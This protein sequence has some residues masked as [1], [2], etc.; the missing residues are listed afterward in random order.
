MVKCL[1]KYH[2]KFIAFL[3]FELQTVNCMNHR[4][5]LIEMGPDP[6]RAYFRPA[7]NKRPTRLWPGYFPTRPEAIFFYRKGKKLKILT[8]L[9][10]IFQILTQTINGWPNPTRV[11]IFWPGPITTASAYPTTYP[12]GSAHKTI[13][14]SSSNTLFTWM[15]LV[16]SSMALTTEHCKGASLFA[17]G[18]AGNWFL[19][20]GKAG[21]KVQLSK[22][23]GIGTIKQAMAEQGHLVG[24]IKIRR[25]VLPPGTSLI[26]WSEDEL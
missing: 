20:L 11:K 3:L 10:E 13:S 14:L 1:N 9:G 22:L 25:E 19:S 6:T 21:G 16:T 2:V 17:G 5:C 23:F 24:P 26:L 18:N 8:F 7:V 4:D 12:L 15:T